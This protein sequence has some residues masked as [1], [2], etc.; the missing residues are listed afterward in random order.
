MEQII[1]VQNSAQVERSADE[2]KEISQLKVN[3][4]EELKNEKTHGEALE[5]CR[6]KLG[7]LLNDV[8]DKKVW[9]D[10]GFK[11]YGDFLESIA[12]MVHKGRTSLYNYADVSRQLLPYISPEELPEVGI[13]KARAL[14]SAVKKN[15]GKRPSDTLLNAA[16]SPAISV[17]EM[18]SLIQDNYGARDEGEKGT[19]M[20]LSGVFFNDEEKDEFYRAVETACKTDPPLKFII[21]DWNEAAAPSRKEI[22]WRWVASYLAENEAN[23]NASD[24][25]F[26]A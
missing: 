1:A 23:A 4:Y 15:S 6:V 2:K 13:T 19:W 10:W 11:S 17:G 12:P 22:L 16:K 24:E 25:V 14:A 7:M 21:K 18:I 20:E 5:T 3:L 9:G 8:Q 26:G